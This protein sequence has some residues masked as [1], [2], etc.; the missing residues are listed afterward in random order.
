MTIGVL[1]PYRR[2]GIGAPPA[3]PARHP[4]SR[5]AMALALRSRRPRLKES[6][7]RDYRIRT[8]G[9]AT[10][11]RAWDCPPTEPPRPAATSLCTGKALVEQVLKTCQE[12]PD[13]AEIYLHVQVGN[14]DAVE[15]YQKFGFVVGE[16]VKDYYKKLEPADAVLLSKKLN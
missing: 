16:V 11:S 4:A 8:R 5:A 1:A 6:N 2:L 12:K 9:A 10:N 15:F 14:D 3:Q 7:Q 13:C